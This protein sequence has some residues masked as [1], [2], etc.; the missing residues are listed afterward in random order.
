MYNIPIL[1]DYSESESGI[2]ECFVIKFKDASIADEFIKVFEKAC[3][4]GYVK[5]SKEKVDEGC[6]LQI[7]K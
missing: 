1:Q 5:D 6:I 3:K 7:C 4:G 2:D